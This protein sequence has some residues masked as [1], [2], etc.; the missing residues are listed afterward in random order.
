MK[1]PEM[2][3]IHLRGHP[4]DWPNPSGA[5]TTMNALKIGKLVYIAEAEARLMS[6]RGRFYA[7]GFEYADEISEADG[8]F[9]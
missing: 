4:D 3:Y 8:C 7:A 2:L 6:R 9:R 5:I 1:K